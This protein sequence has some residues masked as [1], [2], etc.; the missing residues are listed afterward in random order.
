[1]EINLLRTHLANKPPQPF[2]GN[3]QAAVTVT[4]TASALQLFRKANVFVLSYL[5]T[6]V[7]TVGGLQIL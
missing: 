3:P 6:S 1:M 4:I 7:V 2:L 5:L